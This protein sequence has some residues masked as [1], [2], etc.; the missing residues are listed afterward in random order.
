MK[1]FQEIADNR[2]G[3]EAVYDWA[4]PQPIYNEIVEKTNINPGG[5]VVWLYDKKARVF[6][7]PFGITLLGGIIL[8]IY[9]GGWKGKK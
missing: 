8:T 3:K 5:H 6:G 1:T 2:L 7:R 9:S 4:I